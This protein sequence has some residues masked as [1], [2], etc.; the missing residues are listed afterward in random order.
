[1]TSSTAC[2]VC[3]RQ[4]QGVE[5]GAAHQ[6]RQEVGGVAAVKV[7]QAPRGF[8]VE[9]ALLGARRR[10]EGAA[11]LIRAHIQEAVLLRRRAVPCTTAC[12]ATLMGVLSCELSQLDD[13]LYI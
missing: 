12:L 2:F 9:Q 11:Q 7:A 4:K 8:T 6:G 13:S 1:M 5:K 3:T 10:Q